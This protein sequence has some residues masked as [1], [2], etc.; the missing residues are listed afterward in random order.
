MSDYIPAGH[1]I[2][3]ELKRLETVSKGGIILNHGTKKTM[4]QTG[5]MEAKVVA[6]G[7]NA[8]KAFDDGEPWCKVGDNVLIRKYAGENLFEVEDINLDV[9]LF[10][11]IEDEDILV[12][13]KGDK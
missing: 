7:M 1:R 4:N 10:R 3:V 11:L 6:L 9:P 5:T 8:F 13:V 12:I 2:L